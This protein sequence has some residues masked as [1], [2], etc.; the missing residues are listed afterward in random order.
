MKDIKGYNTSNPIDFSGI[1][2]PHMFY[3]YTEAANDVEFFDSDIPG[4]SHRAK[5]KIF[6]RVRSSLDYC[7]SAQSS[8]VRSF[9]V[10]QLP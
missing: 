8:G 7:F 1:G 2:G 9:L 6:D 10:S 4:V 3:C 5:K